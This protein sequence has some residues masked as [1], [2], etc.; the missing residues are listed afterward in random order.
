MPANPEIDALIGLDASPHDL[1][2]LLRYRPGSIS[3]ECCF[4]SKALLRQPGGFEGLVVD[5]ITRPPGAGGLEHRE[6]VET[7]RNCITRA[8]AAGAATVG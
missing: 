1:H 7:G 5:R 8:V 4:S 6:L 2:V 3:D